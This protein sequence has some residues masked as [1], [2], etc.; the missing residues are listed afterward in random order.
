MKQND[1]SLFWGSGQ[2][3]GKLHIDVKKKIDFE[4]KKLERLYWPQEITK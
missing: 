2:Y 4:N 1:F 3:E